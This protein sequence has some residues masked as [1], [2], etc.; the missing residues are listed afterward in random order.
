MTSSG[1]KPGRSR[2]SRTSSREKP[3][4]RSESTCCNRAIA[5]VGALGLHQRGERLR[6]GDQ[7]AAVVTSRVF[8]TLRITFFLECLTILR[9]LHPFPF[10]GA[11]KG[12][13]LPLSPLRASVR[14]LSRG[15]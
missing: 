7:G 1:E 15:R 14:R 4:C 10:G 5:A 2:Q 6:A 8:V 11:G 13:R 9:Y 3:S 12:R